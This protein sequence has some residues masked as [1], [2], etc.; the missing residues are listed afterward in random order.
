MK[1]FI[2][3]LFLFLSY[4]FYGFHITR[5]HF[6]LTEQLFPQSQSGS[7]H[8]YRMV[9]NIHSKAN[10]G[11]ASLN[12]IVL[13]AQKSNLDYMILTDLN[14]FPSNP[15]H[16]NHNYFNQMLVSVFGEYSY[17]DSHLLLFSNRIHFQDK[18]PSKIKN[19]G[20]MQIFLTDALSQKQKDI[21]PK[22][23]QKEA[24][25]SKDPKDKNLIFLAHPLQKGF[26]WKSISSSSGLD[27]IEIIKLNS[28]LDKIWKKNKWN[29][30]HSLLVFPFNWRL[31][32]VRLIREPKPEI[33]LWDQFN[34]KHKTLAIAGSNALGNSF[35]SY[36]QVF[37]IVSNHIILKSELTGHAQKDKNK[38][39]MA[40]KKGQ[41]YICFDIIASCKG[42]Q[43]HLQ[44]K[45]SPA[46]PE[47]QL[48]GFKEHEIFYLGQRLPL[49]DNL[50]LK[51]SMS[52]KMPSSS[53]IDVFKDGQL[54]HSSQKLP[55]QIPIKEKGTYRLRI[56]LWT[57]L[58]FP[59]QS[60]WIPWIYTN[61]FF[62]K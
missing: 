61:P 48:K 53:K 8:T 9:T 31:A 3:I 43:F 52:N 10:K 15:I 11:A 25:D 32:F 39:L 27:G 24:K 18:N 58:P 21:S 28:L 55:L 38:L 30:L 13:Q 62:V 46:K 17:L 20:Q 23:T 51:V 7:T 19:L 50:E 42:F 47:R 54:F 59:D 60:R 33:R 56:S 12:E 6:P 35:V 45:A 14:F 37:S 26:Q 40:L 36:H 2:F 4:L 5:F 49:Q 34:K 44:Q 16:L 22:D 1:I 57:S 29:V 41:F